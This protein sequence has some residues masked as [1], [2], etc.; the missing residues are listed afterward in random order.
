MGYDLE[1]LLDELDSL[2]F[3]LRYLASDLV[4]MPLGAVYRILE[5]RILK[6]KFEAWRS[7]KRLFIHT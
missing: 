2:P 5:L 3:S 6:H 4:R 1:Q 7:G